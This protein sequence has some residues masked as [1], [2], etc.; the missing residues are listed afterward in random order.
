[1]SDATPVKTP[2]V[3]GLISDSTPAPA[4]APY[5]SLVGSLLYASVATRPDISEAVARLCRS[6]KNPTVSDWT[7]AKRVL[8]YL[9]GTSS[10]GITFSAGPSHSPVLEAWADAA[11]ADSPDRKSQT[12]YII[13][14]NNGAVSWKST[15][16]SVV[17]LSTAEA[18][19]ISLASTCMEINFLRQLLQELGHPQTTPTL[20][21]EDNNAAI[22]MATNPTTSAAARHIDI[23][24]HFVRDYIQRNLVRITHCPTGDMLAD[25]LTKPLPKPQFEALTKRFMGGCPN[26]PAHEEGC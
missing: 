26:S 16:Q 15:R 7:A 1:M 22:V 12:G 2:A 19:Y 11:W 25:A 24:L 4:D 10:Q 20:V 5:A 6:M 13:L 9:K 17:A 21:H 3:T 8:R 14:L 18:E 23:R